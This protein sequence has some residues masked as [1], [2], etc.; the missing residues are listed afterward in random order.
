MVLGKLLCDHETLNAY[1]LWGNICMMSGFSVGLW[2]PAVTILFRLH[3]V[4]AII[5]GALWGFSN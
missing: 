1:Y 2:S 4:L 5:E 3:D